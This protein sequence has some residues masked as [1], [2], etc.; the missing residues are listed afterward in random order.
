[1]IFIDSNEAAQNPMIVA[2]LRRKTEVHVTPLASGDIAFWGMIGGQKLRVGIELKQTPDDLIGSLRDGRLITQL[3]AMTEEYDFPYLVE[4]GEPVL[5]DL[6][7]ETLTETARG[8][9][10]T[11]TRFPFHFLNSILARFEISGGRIRNVRDTE[12]LALF[13]HSLQR[14]WNKTQHSDGVEYWENRKLLPWKL[15]KED[16]L[17]GIYGGM[18]IGLKRAKALAAKFP[19]F[20][21]LVVAEETELLTLDG[22]GKKSAAKVMRYVRGVDGE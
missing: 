5:V 14:Y 9:V 18:G 6:A 21:D 15:F 20:V 8:D 7:M 19:T 1:M 17:V 3:P 12:H 10:S 11:V 16:P 13:I 22:F 4:V 2:L